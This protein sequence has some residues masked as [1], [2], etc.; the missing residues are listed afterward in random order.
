[1][2]SRRFHWITNKLRSQP[3]ARAL[4]ACGRKQQILSLFRALHPLFLEAVQ[5]V[6][7]TCDQIGSKISHPLTCPPASSAVTPTASFFTQSSLLTTS[8]T[9]FPVVRVIYDFTPTSPFEL[10]VHGQSA[11]IG[12]ALL[13]FRIDPVRSRGGVCAC[14]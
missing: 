2:G 10:A 1:M 9:E 6:R 13:S 5:E 12:P 8:E 7:L 3:T 11:C 4:A 14:H